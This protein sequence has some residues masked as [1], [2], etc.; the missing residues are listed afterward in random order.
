MKL[1]EIS[2]N[3]FTL[4]KKCS[5]PYQGNA[6]FFTLIE[7]LVVIAII[8]ILAS[9]LLPALNQAREKGREATCKGNM[10]S[11][12]QYLI[13]YVD[14]NNDWILPARDSDLVY[15]TQK[16]WDSHFVVNDLKL[17]TAGRTPQSL[18]DTQKQFKVL[19][20]PGSPHVYET[21]FN[22]Y[23]YTTYTMNHAFGYYPHTSPEEFPARND[24]SKKIKADIRKITSVPRPGAVAV[25]GE[26]P[27]D[28]RSAV[29]VYFSSGNYY[30]TYLGYP[31]GNRANFVFLDGHM[32]SNIKSEVDYDFAH[33]GLVK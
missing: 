18:R 15:A 22:A 5:I 10:K 23:N 19:L 4:I 33:S 20:C 16:Q 7:L 29:N 24:S 28:Y 14:S 30:F 1:N 26:G 9:M 6:K 27:R 31:H 25:F 2:R 8:A 32:S 11:L 21:I 17:V 12:H 3:I 13:N